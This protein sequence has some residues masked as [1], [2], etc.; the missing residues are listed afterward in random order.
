MGREIARA[1]WLRNGM[2]QLVNVYA[3]ASTKDRCVICYTPE[4]R[5][6]AAYLSV[7]L[8]ELR[9]PNELVG[10]RPFVDPEL[11]AELEKHLPVEADLPGNLV[12]FT[13]ERE[14]LSHFSVFALLF[15]R[16]GRNRVKIVRVISASDELFASGLAISPTELSIRNATL[17]ELFRAESEVRVTS[18]AGT[19]LRVH[20]DNEKYDWISNR[21]EWRPGAFMILPAGE[22]A[23]YAERIEGTLVADGAIHAN[24]VTNMDVRL[25]RSPLRITIENSVAQSV[26]CANREIT[27]FVENCFD[28]PNVRQ[29][30]ELGFGT[31]VEAGKF[32][33]YNSHLNERLPGVHLGF[34]QHNQP[35]AVVSYEATIHLDVITDD[36]AIYLPQA[37]RTVVLSKLCSRP[38]ILH[39]ELLR[40]EDIT[41]DCCGDTRSDV[42]YPV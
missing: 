25:K 21:G 42:M 39:P 32:I 3:C 30:G 13:I 28:R 2:H 12:V 8:S 9:I 14:A 7:T 38:G 19:D 23:T 29:V 1:E 33:A 40:D 18:G 6:Y 34:G 20:L 15:D 10:M 22:I 37:K 17:L 4:S 41:G 36:A 24:V 5:E 27:E 26:D 16:Y 35:K 31:N 11:P